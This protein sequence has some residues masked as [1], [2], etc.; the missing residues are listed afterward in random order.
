MRDGFAA[1]SYDVLLA[2]TLGLAASC[3][4]ALKRIPNWLTVFIA[5]TGIAAR[6]L[7]G[8]LLAAASSVGA[9]VAVGALLAPLWTRRLLGAGDLKLAAAAAAWIGL[10]GTPRFLVA[11]ALAGGVVSLL[12]YVRSGARARALSRANLLQ[13][14]VPALA[15]AGREPVHALV[16]YGV[17]IAAG[18]AFAVWG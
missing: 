11:A 17:A 13:F 8:G 16:P 6:A 12:A 3:D 10:A 5:A 2:A 9:A 4:V 15:Y 7:T 18:A 1:L 14:H